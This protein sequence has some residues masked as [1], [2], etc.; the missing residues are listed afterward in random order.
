MVPENWTANV[1]AYPVV[2]ESDCIMEIA[3]DAEAHAFAVSVITTSGL[4]E[5]VCDCSLRG[6]ALLVSA[7]LHSFISARSAI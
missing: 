4:L 1:R 2:F 7:A 6:D 3:D 5:H